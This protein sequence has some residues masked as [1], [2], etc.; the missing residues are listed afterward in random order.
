MTKAFAFW[1]CT[2]HVPLFVL[3]L[4]RKPVPAEDAPLGEHL[5]GGLYLP[6]HV[7]PLPHPLRGTFA[8]KRSGATTEAGA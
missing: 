5:A 8:S 2:S 1:V 3:Q 7:P 6:V 4:V